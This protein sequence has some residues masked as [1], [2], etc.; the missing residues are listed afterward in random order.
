MINFDIKQP[1]IKD[2]QEIERLSLETVIQ[3]AESY[4]GFA[5]FD[6]QQQMVVQRM[7]HTTT[8]FEQIID[9]IVFINN[10]AEKIINLIQD[11]AKI[12]T[13]TNMIKSGLSKIY[14]DKFNNKVICY[15]SEP[16][17]KSEAIEKGITRTAAAVKKA[18]K[19]SQNTPV[20]LACGN[21]PTFLYAAVESLIIDNHNL[22][23]VAMISMPVGFINVVESKEYTLEFLEQKKVCGITLKGRYGGSPLVVSA[24]HA[25][26]KLI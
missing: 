19:E 7:I 8:C 21:A 1:E 26:Y 20:I 5:N 3:E 25:L 2:P 18:L 9:N 14:T 15:V 11:E 24:L 16:D 13:D 10:A 23:D 4:S 17:I 12:I 6:A 22:S